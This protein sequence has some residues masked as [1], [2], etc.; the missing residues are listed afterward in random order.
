M[1]SPT[2]PTTT[3]TLVTVKSNNNPDADIKSPDGASSTSPEKDASKD[4]A[5]Q[6]KGGAAIYESNKLI[7]TFKGN[8]RQS[9]PRLVFN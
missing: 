1:T 9:V 8:I 7:P 6:H 4:G 2:P 5:N 3:T